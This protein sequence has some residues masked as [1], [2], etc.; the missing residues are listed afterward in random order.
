MLKQ[1]YIAIKSTRHD[2]GKKLSCR[3][4]VTMKFSN[5]GQVRLNPYNPTK[6]THKTKDRVTRTPQ[7]I[8]KLNNLKVFMYKG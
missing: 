5:V 7:H 4:S 2:S 8:A 3:P 1:Q 6:H